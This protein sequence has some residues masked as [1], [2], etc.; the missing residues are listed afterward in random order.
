[1]ELKPKAR[2]SRKRAKATDQDQP[3]AKPSSRPAKTSSRPPAKT[4]SKLPAKG[5]SGA[6]AKGR[7]KKRKSPPSV[8]P[9]AL[10]D[11]ISPV[12]NGDGLSDSG[13][14]CVLP[15]AQQAL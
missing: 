8:E 9:V 4:S 1:M 14:A 5:G 13:A 11:S 3:P 2:S 6:V 10:V 7:G 15:Y 12:T